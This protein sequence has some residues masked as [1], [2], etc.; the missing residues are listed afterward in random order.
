MVFSSICEPQFSLCVLAYLKAFDF[1]GIVKILEK[2][3]RVYIM[4]YSFF[5]EVRGKEKGI[6]DL[7]ILTVIPLFFAIFEYIHH[8]ITVLRCLE[9]EEGFSNVDNRIASQ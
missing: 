1:L 7:G 8:C 3:L 9:V 6:S 2:L 4:L 5:F